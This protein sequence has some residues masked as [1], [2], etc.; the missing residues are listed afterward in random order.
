MGL[1]NMTNRVKEEV[2]VGIIAEIIRILDGKPKDCDYFQIFETY[3]NKLVNRDEV[4]TRKEYK[5]GYTVKKD[6]KLWAIREKENNQE[7]WTILFPDE[8]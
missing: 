3:N 8:Y 7:C 4:P 2:E 6:I 1:I 5:L